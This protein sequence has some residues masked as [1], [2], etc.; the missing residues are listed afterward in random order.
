[1]VLP[2]LRW[3]LFSGLD[4]FDIRYISEVLFAPNFR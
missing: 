3:L 2:Q 1:M 4:V